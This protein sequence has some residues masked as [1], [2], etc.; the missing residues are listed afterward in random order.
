MTQ[1][2]L[3]SHAR[4]TQQQLSKVENAKAYKVETLFK[5]C[6]A[7]GMELTL[8][9]RGDGRRRAV[10]RARRVPQATEGNSAAC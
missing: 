3:A 7:L 8:K 9:P 1:S 2:A 4:I 5:V 6:D 10:P